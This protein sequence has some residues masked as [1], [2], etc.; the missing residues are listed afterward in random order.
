MSRAV[1]FCTLN[2]ARRLPLCRLF[3]HTFQHRVK[4]AVGFAWDFQILRFLCSAIVEF[5][6]VLQRFYVFRLVHRAAD[7][8]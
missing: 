3:S 6:R 1:C 2:A 5:L 7:G 4:P 8:F